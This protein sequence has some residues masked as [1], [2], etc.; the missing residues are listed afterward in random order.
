MA[1]GGQ[2]EAPGTDRKEAPP[3]FSEGIHIQIGVQPKVKCGSEINVLL[4][5]LSLL[6][7]CLGYK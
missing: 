5:I 3:F 4:K 1:T 7:I 2:G 6:F